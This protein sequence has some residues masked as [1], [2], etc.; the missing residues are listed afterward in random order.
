MLADHAAAAEG[1][2]YINGGGWSVTGPVPAPSAI[3]ILIQVPW[4]QTNMHHQLRLELVDADGQ[5]VMVEGPEGEQPLFVE[6]GFEVGRPPGIRPGTPLDV[7][8]ALNLGPMP[9]PPGGRFTWQLYIDGETR[10]EWYLSFSTRQ[11]VPGMPPQ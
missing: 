4:D 8:L 9:L 5:P 1:K 11:A 10:E 3:A 6:A 7:P 2:L